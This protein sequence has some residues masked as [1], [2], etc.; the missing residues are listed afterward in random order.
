MSPV[1]LDSAVVDLR[2]TIK[3]WIWCLSLLSTNFIHSNSLID[4]LPPRLCALISY[5]LISSLSDPYLW[6]GN[7]KNMSQRKFMGRALF[8]SFLMF[9][10]LFL[11]FLLFFS[12]IF[13]GVALQLS[14]CSSVLLLFTN[15]PIYFR[16]SQNFHQFISNPPGFN[17][18]L[19]QCNWAQ[20]DRQRF[21]KCLKPFSPKL[22]QIWNFRRF[23]WDQLKI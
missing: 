8:S 15:F 19:P 11:F 23:T 12:S 6:T 9:F 13:E 17:V 4:E 10:W 16:N 20:F 18:S 22:A 3:V 21:P 2:M 1:N 5:I 14:G 7:R